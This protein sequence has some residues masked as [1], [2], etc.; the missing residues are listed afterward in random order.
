MYIHL[1]IKLHV[2]SC[3]R[4]SGSRPSYNLDIHV[5]QLVYPKKHGGKTLSC[6]GRDSNLSS[7]K[8]RAN[9]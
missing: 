9:R 7:S 4:T 8:P 6:L 3:T 2:Y 1:Q 5:H